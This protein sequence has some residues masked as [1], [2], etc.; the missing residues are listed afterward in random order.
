M[1]ALSEVLASTLP[2]SHPVLELS[3]VPILPS[4]LDSEEMPAWMAKQAHGILWTVFPK[5]E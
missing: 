5:G 4:S 3:M 2:P 1:R